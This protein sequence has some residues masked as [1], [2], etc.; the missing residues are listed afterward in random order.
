LNNFQRPISL[1]RMIP[2]IIIGS[3]MTFDK[4]FIKEWFLYW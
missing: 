3:G 2:L 1:E 4:K